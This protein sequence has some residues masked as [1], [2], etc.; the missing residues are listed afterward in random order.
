MGSKRSMLLNGLGD[1]ICAAV[2]GYARFVDLFAGSASVSWH[3]AQ[4]YEIPVL[5]S[6]LQSF[7]VILAE[8][9]IS[10]TKPFDE[11]GLVKWN[12]RAA[13]VVGSSPIYSAALECDGQLDNAPIFE[14][15]EF[16]KN[17]SRADSGVITS[18]YGGYYFSPMQGLWLDAF[19]KTLPSD[20]EGRSLC[21]AALIWAAS[22][23]AASPGHTAQPFKANETAGKFLREAWK[24]DIGRYVHQ[25]F[26][27]IAPQHSK[28]KGSACKGDANELA[29]KLRDGDLVFLD[30]PYSDVH[31]SRFYHVLETLATNGAVSVSGVGRYPPASDRP[32]S[33]Y[34]K[35]STSYGALKELLKSLSVVGA[36]AIITFPA[37]NAS[38]GL[39]GESV[40]AA[41]DEYFHIK[42]EKVTGRFSTLGGNL[43]GRE[44]RIVSN[45]LILTMTPRG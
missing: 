2:P 38:N 44:A 18:A 7:S 21:L 23:C 16:A 22:R 40:R 15:A 1:A 42:S 5:A 3:V 26:L 45:E 31:Y 29:G 10:R 14:V 20:S 19:R 43:R 17:I 4:K 25:S 6:D 37:G 32:Q 8:G 35:N 41:A 33:S 12:E 34:S 39:S 13:R 36:G 24:R 30:P 9:V 11:A 27:T 28:I